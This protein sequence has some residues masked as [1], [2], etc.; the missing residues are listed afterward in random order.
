MQWNLPSGVAFILSRLREKGYEAYVVGGSVRDTLRGEI[1]HDYDVT[2]SALPSETAALFSDCRTVDTGLK[3]G[4]L[5]VLYGD[6]PYEVTTYRVDGGYTDGRHPDEVSFAPSLRE[7]A[8]RRDFTVNAMAYA[9]ESGVIDFFGGKQDLE[10][11]ILRTVGDPDRR[12]SEDALRILRALRFAATLDFSIEEK[13]AAS[14][15]RNKDLLLKISAERIRDELSKLLCG[16]AAFRILKEYRDVMA[17]CIPELT[18]TFDF[19]QRSKHHVYDLYL[20]T[21]HVLCATPPNLTLRMAALLHDVGKP[22]TFSIDREGNGHF[23]GHAERSAEMADTVLRRLRF[24]NRTRERI[25]LLVEKH[26]VELPATERS[27]KRLLRSVGEQAF[28]EL[29]TLKKADIAA[30]SPMHHPRIAEIKSIETAARKLLSDA[31]CFSL[32]ELAVNGSD[33]IKLGVSEGK[34]IGELL[35]ACLEAVIDGRVKNERE[36]LLAFAA[37]L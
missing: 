10:N 27:L 35:D 13:T 21:L 12:F 15:C 31:A 16:K 18:A 3:H 4:T 19:A 29:M 2:T 37:A 23:Y 33:M 11:R 34:R 1:P 24:D 5:T 20:H 7:D 14:V 9:P 28:F 25:I 30:L 22:D 32:R 17:V 36:A 26:G 8:A 6:V